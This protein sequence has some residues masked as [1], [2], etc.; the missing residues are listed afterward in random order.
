MTEE[1]KQQALNNAVDMLRH[2]IDYAKKARSNSFDAWGNDKC[3]ART[4]DTIQAM[5][6]GNASPR[7]Y[8]YWL[9]H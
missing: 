9:K 1:Q 6:Q 7:Q 8:D 4:V 3:I 2:R 5:K